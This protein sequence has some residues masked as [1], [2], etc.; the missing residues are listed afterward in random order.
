MVD[1]NSYAEFVLG[2]LNALLKDCALAYPA[3]TKEF[4]RDSSRLSSA[5]ES[6][7]IRF[8]L[9]TMP[10]MRKHL[11]KCV[12]QQHLT[13]SH[14]TH[15]GPGRKGEVV[16]RLFRGLFLRV[17]DRSGVLKCDADAHALRLLRQLLGAVRKM[18]LECDLGDRCEAV[19]EF[20]RI[21]AAVHP[22][23]LK[24]ADRDGL[25]ETKLDAL[26]FEE[27]AQDGPGQACLEDTPAV[28]NISYE[29]A[30]CIQRVADYIS[31]KLGSFD[32]GEWRFKHGP[33]AVADQDFGAYRYAFETWPDRLER[34]FPY[35]DFAHAN[36]AC[37]VPDLC[38]S[39]PGLAFLNEKPARLHAVPKTI[40][41]PRLIASEPV[42]LQWCQQA[43][44]DYMYTR[45]SETLLSNFVDFRRQGLNG[46]LALEASHSRSHAT[47]DL[48]SASDRISPW[49]IERLFR[50]TPTLLMALQATRSVWMVQDIDKKSPKYHLL[51]KFSTMGNAT[52]F[53][54]Q[55]LFFLSI[56]LGTL[57]HVRK[58]RISDMF[59]RFLGRDTVRVFG[60]DIIVPE[61]CAEQVV[62]ALEAFNLKVNTNKTFTEGNF[63][64]SC[65]VDAFN[66]HDVTTV[67][68]LDLPERARPGSVVS[69][70]D[71]HN[72]LCEEG[73]M[74][75]AQYIQKTV[76]RVVSSK[77][78]CVSHGSGAF[79]WSDRK[80][81]V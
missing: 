18:K 65:G 13:L 67:S 72:N 36:Y 33:G 10:A 6:H 19:A 9:D 49:H 55:S 4:V 54:V 78:Q 27:I 23:T 26:S 2:T 11:D 58:A 59:F 52:T 63:R 42:A 61:D 16:P 75:T 74:H 46:N 38:T 57:V 50:K 47:I 68:I 71:V 66:G 45:V 28:A 7:G 29:H 35:A 44:R 43:I 37:A 22:G 21:D 8:A 5:I 53:P 79:G 77:I 62:Q 30:R 81:V 14:L 40:T 31:S 80:S 39:K 41:T 73:Y 24:W 76:A 60:D 51:R 1:K 64:E 17:F 56:A 69:S 25:D 34:V 15:F 12:A 32:P 3:L 70:V 20:F 48:S